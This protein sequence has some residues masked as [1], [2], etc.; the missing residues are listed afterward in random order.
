MMVSPRASA[1]WIS[2]CRARVL[3]ASRPSGPGAASAAGGPCYGVRRWFLQAGAVA[4]DGA[5]DGLGQVMRQGAG[6][7]PARCPQCG[8]FSGG[9]QP[10]RRMRLSPH[11]ALW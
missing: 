1:A 2:A 6:R 10:E 3:A 7:P 4:G 5:F 8:S 11:T 9:P